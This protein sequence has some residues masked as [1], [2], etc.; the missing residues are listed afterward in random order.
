M[1][2]ITDPENRFMKNKKGRIKLSY[3]PQLMVGKEGIILAND[4]TQ[5]PIDTVQLQPQVHQTEENLRGLP[6]NIV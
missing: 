4:L 3:N 5:N 2:S 1:I 6:E